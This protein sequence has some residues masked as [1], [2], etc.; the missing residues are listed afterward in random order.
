M[1]ENQ[2]KAVN[3]FSMKITSSWPN[4]RPIV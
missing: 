4:T 1:S 3:L 2:L